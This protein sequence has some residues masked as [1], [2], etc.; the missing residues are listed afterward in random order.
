MR[1]KTVLVAGAA[2]GYLFGTR[3]GRQR[4]EQIKDRAERVWQ[5]PKVQEKIAQ[6]QVLA[7]EKGA[8]LRRPTHGRAAH[9]SVPGGGL[10]G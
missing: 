6:A 5:D 4:Y 3:A 9:E 8:T 2:A 10:D 1:G 7:R